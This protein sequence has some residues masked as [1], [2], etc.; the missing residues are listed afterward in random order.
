[1][2]IACGWLG[3]GRLAEPDAIVD[4]AETLLRPAGPL[5]GRRVL[6]TAGPTYEDVDPVRFL[7]NRSSG[8]MGYAIAEEAVARGA[9]VVLVSGP[10]NLK[11]PKGVELV[12][13]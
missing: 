8:R 10:V 9:R 13:A 5:A 6:V 12:P 2:S 1:M 7:G 3:K 11:A 4:A